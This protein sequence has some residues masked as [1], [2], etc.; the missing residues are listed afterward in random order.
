MDTNEANAAIADCKDEAIADARA[1]LFGLS[2]DI[3]IGQWVTLTPERPYIRRGWTAKVVDL[4][5]SE[6][7]IVVTVITAGGLEVGVEKM[8]LLIDEVVPYKRLGV[9]PTQVQAWINKRSHLAI[10]HYSPIFP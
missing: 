6:R 8:D 4:N 9:P 2:C 10:R 7:G 5:H 1:I 3:Q